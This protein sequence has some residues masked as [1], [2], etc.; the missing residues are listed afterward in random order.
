MDNIKPGPFKVEKKLGTVTYRLALPTTIR[1]H[2]VFYK[3]LLERAELIVELLG[4]IL[5]DEES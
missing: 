4:P 3:E 5:L 2:L 1:V